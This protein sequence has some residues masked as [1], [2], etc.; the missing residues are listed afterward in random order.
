MVTI[1]AHKA[2]GSFLGRGT[3]VW[4]EVVRADQRK[5]TFSGANVDGVL[6]VAK[7]LPRDFDKIATRG[8]VVVE[9]PEGVSQD[10][11]DEKIIESGVWFREHMSKSLTYTSFFPCRDGYGNCGTVVNEVVRRAGG[12]IPKFKPLGFSPGLVAGC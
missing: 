5:V 2:Y 7:N 6:A 9:P 3:H 11:W 12:K 8:S 4:I 10:D 1:K